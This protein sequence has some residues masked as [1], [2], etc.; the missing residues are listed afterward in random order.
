VIGHL[1]HIKEGGMEGKEAEEQTT[2][3]QKKDGRS[4]RFSERT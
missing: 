2:M 1:K 4:L 3:I